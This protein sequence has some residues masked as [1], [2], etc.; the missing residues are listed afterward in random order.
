M[1]L[2]ASFITY[3]L[4]PRAEMA[5]SLVFL[6]LSVHLPLFL[7]RNQLVDLNLLWSLFAYTSGEI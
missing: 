1:A 5:A 4:Y 2:K 3:E 6:L 7:F